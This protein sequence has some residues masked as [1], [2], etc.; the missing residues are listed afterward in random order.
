MTARFG[1]KLLAAVKVLFRVWHRRDAEPT[2]RWKRDAEPAKKEVFAVVQR[3][4]SRSETQNV[5]ERFRE[6]G[7]Y[8]FT[9]LKVPGV[10]PTNNAMERGFRHLVID[11]KVMQGTRGEPGRRWCERIWTVLATCAQ[12]GRSA[13]Q[14]IYQSIVAYFTDHSFASLLPQGP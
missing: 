12:Q 4:P 5:A 13:F 3:A 7:E 10:E 11:R 8:Y 9:F 2:E 14:C 6:Y 1:A